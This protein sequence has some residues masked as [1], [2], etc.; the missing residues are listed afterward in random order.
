[1]ANDP[2]H[3]LGLGPQSTTTEIK[4]A[5]RTLAKA[6]H[7]DSAG[8]AA[9]PRFLAIQA[10]YEHLM[11]G[12]GRAPGRSREGTSS[13]EPWR[14]DP[15]RAQE[16][17]GGARPGGDRAAGSRSRPNAGRPPGQTG[18]AAGSGPP[19][20]AR[21][22]ATRKATFGST[23]YDEAHDPADPTWQGAAWYGPSSGE[24]WTVNP[25][26]YA[27]PRKHGPEYQA[28]AA[29]RAARAEARANEARANEARPAQTRAATAHVRRSED[30]PPREAAGAQSG[31]A[32]AETFPPSGMFDWSRLERNSF[33]RFL[34]ALA[35]WPPL[36]ITAA[37]VIGQS[38]GC[39]VFSASCTSGSALLPWLA[40]VVIL[41]ALVLVPSLARLLIGGTVAVAIVAFPVAAAL[42][43]G[44]A[45]YDRVYGPASFIAALGLAWVVG[46][47]LMVARVFRMRS[48]A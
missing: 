24:Y 32:S 45:D 17:R 8:E 41:L 19:G 3:V 7:P 13:A 10:A 5:Y 4:R 6:N 36:G 38:T 42:S 20:G 22:R 9:L 29:D 25:R 43:A 16:A 47:G 28:R 1:M 23:T 21:R 11:A 35:A 40:Q 48:A 34:L 2:L 37:S 14:A 12:K 30:A 15:E 31:E 33:R 26:E 27:D 39:A 46:V 44:G 18:R